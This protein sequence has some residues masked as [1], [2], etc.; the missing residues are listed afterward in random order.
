MKTKSFIF[1]IVLSIILG[2]VFFRRSDTTNTDYLGKED[3]TFIYRL[4]Q[5]SDINR[6]QIYPSLQDSSNEYAT[7]SKNL[8]DQLSNVYEEDGMFYQGEINY[9]DDVECILNTRQKVGVNIQKCYQD[10]ISNL[11]PNIDIL[12][13]DGTHSKHTK[14]NI[15]TLEENSDLLDQHTLPNEQYFDYAPTDT[16]WNNY[17]SLD[18]YTL[19]IKATYYENLILTY[20]RNVNMG[21][22]FIDNEKIQIESFPMVTIM[23]KIEVPMLSQEELRQNIQDKKVRMISN[24]AEFNGDFSNN[25]DNLSLNNIQ[26][27]YVYYQSDS[28]DK[29]SYFLP[30]YLLCGIAYSAGGFSFGDTTAHV[31]GITEAIDYEKITQNYPNISIKQVD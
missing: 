17:D 7:V 2:V 29:E 9:V 1:V 26:K 18:Y 13:F 15:G 23:K 31:C 21:T 4:Y 3:N 16:G 8:I 28:S 6:V 24:T 25:E 19:N 10:N 30:Y 5:E 12:L 11:D 27:V 22:I 20:P 14:R